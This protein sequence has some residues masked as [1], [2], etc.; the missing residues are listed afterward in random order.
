[1]HVHDHPSD[2]TCHWSDVFKPTAFF[3]FRLANET[4]RREI[5]ELSHSEEQWRLWLCEKDDALGVLNMVKVLSRIC[6]RIPLPF[7]DDD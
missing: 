3:L 5:T 7:I 1:M 6:L 4:L 2:R